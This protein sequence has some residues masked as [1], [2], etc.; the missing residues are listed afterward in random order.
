MIS[1]STNNGNPNPDRSPACPAARV[2]SDK[3]FSSAK[4]TIH[5]G[6]PEARTQPGSPV[7]GTA[8]QRSLASRK[9]ANRWSSLTCQN[10]AEIRS[11]AELTRR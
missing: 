4:S 9:A 3:G 10:P 11:S 7:P 8:R 5:C 6:L 2:R 1:S